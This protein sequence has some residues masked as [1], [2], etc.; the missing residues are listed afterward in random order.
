MK[1]RLKMNPLGHFC[2]QES[3]RWV[4]QFKYIEFEKW[5]CQLLASE[6]NDECYWLLNNFTSVLKSKQDT[7]RG[8]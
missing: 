6:V 3:S 1:F 5:R 4:I 8:K 2:H 7:N